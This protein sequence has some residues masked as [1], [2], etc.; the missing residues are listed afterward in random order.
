MTL[1]KNSR[2]PITRHLLTELFSRLKISTEHFY[3]NSPCWEWTGMINGEKY[4][5]VQYAL[6]TYA[7][8]RVMYETFV[9]SV[10]PHLRCDH[11]CR[12]RH[13]VNPCHLEI[14]TDRENILRGEGICAKFVQQTHCKH[15][16][17]FTKANTYL[18]KFKNG[19]LHRHC[20]ECTKARL[21]KFYRKISLLPHTDPR[22]IK[23]RHRMSSFLKHSS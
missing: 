21:N 11:L 1:A 22:F 10:P 2:F 12:T 19:Q 15:G 4:G 13:C 7:A 18:R 23:H 3:N 16:H 5:A 14:V 9:E 8:H 20:R 6:K 17:E